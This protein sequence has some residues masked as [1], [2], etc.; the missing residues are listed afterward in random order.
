MV[1]LTVEIR[2]FFIDKVIDVL[3][4]WLVV[5]PCTQVHGQG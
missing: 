4:A 3:V 1:S 2:Q 5:G